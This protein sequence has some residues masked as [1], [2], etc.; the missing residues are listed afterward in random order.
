MEVSFTTRR[1]LFS[2]G[3]IAV[4][5]YILHVLIGGFLWKGYNHLQQPISDLTAAGAPNQ[6]LMLVFTTTYGILALFFAL[7]IAILE[8]PHHNKIVAWGTYSFVMMHLVS[9]SYGIFPEDL[10]GSEQTFTGLMHIVV[11]ALIVPFTIMTPLLL[12]LGFRKEQQ[13]RA[14]GNYSIITSVLIFIFG[15]TSALF[16]VNKY[17]FFGIIE[18]LNIGTL[19]IWTLLLSLKLI[20]TKQYQ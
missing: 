2:S 13:W 1:F 16:F 7:S 19:Q 10:K 5:L 4:V 12:G 14:W 11:T 3:L 15:G 17:P 6:S 9:L 18:R 20:R 8:R